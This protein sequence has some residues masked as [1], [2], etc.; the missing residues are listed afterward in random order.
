YK[1][2]PDAGK[3]IFVYVLNSGINAEHEEF[4]GRVIALRVFTGGLI[5]D[6]SHGTHVAG[7]IGGAT[8]GVA[9]KASIIDVQVLAGRT[10]STAKIIKGLEWAIDDIKRN[11]RVGE[12]VISMS[13]GGNRG[14]L[15][16]YS[17][18]LVKEAIDAGIPI[19]MAAR[20]RNMDSDTNSP[21][22]V[23]AAITVGAMTKE[24]RRWE[25]PSLGPIVDIFAPGKGIIAAGS[26]SNT[27]LAT[28]TG[29]SVAAPHVAGVVLY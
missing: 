17:E 16:N 10:G 27:A 3:G 8:Y 2:R 25:G 9:Q 21:G 28:K 13:L 5:S 19:I 11:G 22:R 1:Y 7:I 26:E 18:T 14:R 20:N 24:Y 12:A 6:R 23:T 15:H 4:E 29:T